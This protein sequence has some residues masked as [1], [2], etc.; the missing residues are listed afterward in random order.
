MKS[1]HSLC[2]NQVGFIL[3]KCKR[4]YDLPLCMHIVYFYFLQEKNAHFGTSDLL[5]IEAVLCCSFRRRNL[6]L[7]FE[8]AV[9]MIKVMHQYSHTK[10]LSGPVCAL[11][12][13]QHCHFINE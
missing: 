11:L 8:G 6:G 4:K 1:G 2:L 5:F 9:K 12:L 7:G 13:L 3:N 10:G